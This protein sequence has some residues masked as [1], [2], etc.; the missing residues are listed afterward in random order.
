MTAPILAM[1]FAMCGPLVSTEAKESLRC[2]RQ[3]E[4]CIKVHGAK[5]QEA[6]ET[7]KVAD[8]LLVCMDTEMH[9]TEG[10]H[11]AGKK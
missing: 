5:A 2:V 6:K 4:M 11:K 8:L 10:V 7:L 3:T 1:I 9:R